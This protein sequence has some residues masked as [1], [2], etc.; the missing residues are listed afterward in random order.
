MTSETAGQGEKTVLT[1]AGNYY[2]QSLTIKALIDGDVYG[3]RKVP[4]PLES[5]SFASIKKTFNARTPPP[6]SIDQYICEC[7]HF[8]GPA[9][10]FACPPECSLPCVGESKLHSPTAAHWR[11]NAGERQ[12]ESIKAWPASVSSLIW[13]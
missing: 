11:S 3:A 5:F 2:Y 12:T 10:T 13:T 7:M 8:P 9:F 4:N 6:P 1:L